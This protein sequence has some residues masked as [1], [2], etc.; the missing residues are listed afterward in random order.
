MHW[1]MY[2]VCPVFFGYRWDFVKSK[3]LKMCLKGWLDN[4]MKLYVYFL[5]IFCPQIV[6]VWFR[7]CA[8]YWIHWT[9]ILDMKTVK[10]A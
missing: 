9:Y 7:F 2:N 10:F 1:K 6:L 5:E 3:N 4:Q 8:S